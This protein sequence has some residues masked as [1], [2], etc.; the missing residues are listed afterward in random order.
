V[1]VDVRDARPPSLTVTT[2]IR[3]KTVTSPTVMVEGT[4]HNV[5]QVVAYVD[6]VY[7]TSL[8]LAAGAETFTIAL[9][10]TPGTH[11]VRL[12]GVDAY[13]NTSVSQSVS[14]TYES[15][16]DSGS[17]TA[18]TGDNGST[19]VVDNYLHDTLDAANATKDEATKQVQQA[20]SSGV[21][22]NLSD[23]AFSAFKSV[24]L[25]SST[26]G[27]GINKM[28]GR[29]TLVSVGLA[30]SVF[31]WSTYALIQKIR[32]IPKLA[33]PNGAITLSM[34][35]IGIAMIAIPFIFIH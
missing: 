25:V 7:N 27:T 29:F 22:G 34:R 3:G 8:P 21:L 24:D 35:F 9:G 14:F 20:S 15:A 28:A 16:T 23:I 10:V 13:T 6:E 17:S 12:E 2:N 1:N 4:V 18:G 26:D 30:A 11:D 31:P 33:L 5:T 32:F 19:S